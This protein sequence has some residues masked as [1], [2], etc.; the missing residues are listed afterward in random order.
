MRC[1]ACGEEM[2]LVGIVPDQDAAVEGFERHLLKCSRCRDTEERLVF[3]RPAKFM[4]EHDAPPLSAEDEAAAKEGEERLRQAME[5]TVRGPNR[6]A[7]R[8]AWKRTV[9]GLRGKK[10]EET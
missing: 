1:M 5:T 8:E 4:P 6:V 7:A 10:D 2:L 9:A 3:N